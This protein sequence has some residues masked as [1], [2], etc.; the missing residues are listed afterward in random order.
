[1]TI[2]PAMV[3][4]DTLD[5]TSLAGWWARQT[6]GTVRDD[7]DGWYVMVAP[8]RPGGPVLA[9]QKVEDPTPGKNR[10]H[11]DLTADDRDAEVERLL[12]DGASLVA[13]HEH[14]GF[15]WV[16]LSDPDGNQFCVS[17]AHSA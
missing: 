16:V 9:F 7:S 13:R 11:V 17:Q 10:V 6:G 3:T 14:E 12:A 5:A 15:V 8:T 4:F 2:S 1:M